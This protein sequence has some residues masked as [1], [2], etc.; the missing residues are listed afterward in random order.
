MAWTLRGRAVP[1]ALTGSGL[2][3]QG[4]PSTR[5][6]FMQTLHAARTR[7]ALIPIQGFRGPVLL[8]ADA[9]DQLAPSPISSAQMMHELRHDPAP[10]E[11]R[12]YP[13]VGHVVLGIPS[14][15]AQVAGERGRSL[16][17]SEAAD[18]AAHRT[19]WPLMIRF[20][21]QN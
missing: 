18:D 3:K 7:H 16:G 12:I 14:V 8:L 9:D 2:T 5:L 21:R 15:P 1:Y 17:G 19:D 6:G 10:H 13:R 4:T 20:I 11:R